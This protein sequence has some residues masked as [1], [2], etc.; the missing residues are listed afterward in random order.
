MHINQ[1]LTVVV[2]HPLVGARARAAAALLEPIVVLVDQAEL[3][4]PESL[5]R[6]RY[7]ETGLKNK[8]ENDERKRRRRREKKREDERRTPHPK[9]TKNATRHWLRRLAFQLI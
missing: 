1:T 6:P 2:R 4:D 9:T 8:T 7:R 3:R 5:G